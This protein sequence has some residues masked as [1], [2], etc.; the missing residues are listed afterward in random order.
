M[1]FEVKVY[2]KM[3]SINI[4]TVMFL[5]VKYIVDGILIGGKDFGKEDGL[6]NFSFNLIF[7]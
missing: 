6:N 3:S 7:L 4:L 5:E 1:E 2:I